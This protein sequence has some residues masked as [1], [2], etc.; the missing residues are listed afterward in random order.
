MV[1]HL[2]F[3]AEQPLR[4]SL[5]CGGLVVISEA[6]QPIGCGFHSNQKFFT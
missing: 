4:I 5:R 2:H 3:N 1:S 6:K